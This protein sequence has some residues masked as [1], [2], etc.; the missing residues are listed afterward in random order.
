MAVGGDGTAHEVING[1]LKREDG[2]RLPIS[3]VPNGTG[4]DLVGCFGIKDIEQALRWIVKGDV[5]KMDV[6]KVLMDHEHETD[7]KD[8]KTRLAK[9]R[10]CVIN[11]GCGFVAKVCHKAIKHKPLMG[12]NAYLSA[13]VA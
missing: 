8:S 3:I 5:I 1:M 13:T 11:S 10:Y 2:L 7:I 12:K 4:N 9:F 6:N